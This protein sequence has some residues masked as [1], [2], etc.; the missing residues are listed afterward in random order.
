MKAKFLI[1]LLLISLSSWSQSKSVNQKDS[2]SKTDFQFARLIKYSVMIKDTSKLLNIVKLDSSQTIDSYSAFESDKFIDAQSYYQFYGRIKKALLEEKG[3]F[4]IGDQHVRAKE[5][6][7][8]AFQCDSVDVYIYD[9]QTNSE[10]FVKKFICDSSLIS[11]KTSRIEFYE[12]WYLDPSSLEIKKEVLGYSLQ[13]EVIKYLD[14]E[15]KF[16]R[17]VVTLFKDESAHKKV[18]ELSGK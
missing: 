18:L 16:W 1:P 5:A 7:S 2:N 8:R 13:C 17:D 14:E 11:I 3:Y 12:S 4:V 10:Q 6:R 9:E 15:F